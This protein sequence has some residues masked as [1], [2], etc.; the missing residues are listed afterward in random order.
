MSKRVYQSEQEAQTAQDRA[1]RYLSDVLGDKDR[2]EEIADMSLDEWLED[3]GRRIATINPKT[4][5]RSYTM[6]AK[7]SA[8]RTPTKDDL[9][10]EVEE[11]RSENSALQEA[12]DSTQETLGEANGRLTQIYDLSSDEFE[13]DITYSVDEEDEE[14]GDEDE[15]D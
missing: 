1:V 13:P 9:L 8:A 3:T 7:Q 2:A 11:L 12:L 14:E 15:E 4:E 10:N 5:R 6:P